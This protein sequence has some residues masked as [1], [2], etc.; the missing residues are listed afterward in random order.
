MVKALKHGSNWWMKGGSCF[1]I[2]CDVL[3]QLVSGF[4]LGDSREESAG[5][6]P[7]R[8]A[9]FVL[10]ALVSDRGCVV[11]AGLLCNY[12]RGC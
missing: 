4:F 3:Q 9:E 1:S 5:H 10:L 2:F 8:A 11:L 12:G 7:L 6:V